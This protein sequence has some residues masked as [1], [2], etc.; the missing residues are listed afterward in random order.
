MSNEIIIETDGSF[1]FEIDGVPRR[2]VFASFGE[3]FFARFIDSLIITIPSFCIPIIA[4]W[5]YWAVLQSSKEQST[6]GQRT[7]DIKLLSLRGEDVTFGQ[8]SLR[9]F[10]NA[11][12]VLTCGLGFIFFFTG[13]KKQCLHDS[14][15]DTLVVK[16]IKS[17]S[18]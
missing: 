3:R 18:F 12:N 14:I 2:F 1:E 5:L 17:L 9:F 10:A 4:G 13:E 7:F 8:A 15:A 16:E 11:L 6:I